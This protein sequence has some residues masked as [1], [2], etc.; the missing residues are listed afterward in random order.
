M[1]NKL[2]PRKI[3]LI[4]P[5]YGTFAGGGERAF[6]DLSSKFK[7]VGIEIEVL[8]TCSR[9]PYEDWRR[10]CFEPGTYQVDQMTVRR[11][12][13]DQTDPAP[14]Y[15]VVQ[16]RWRSEQISESMQWDFFTYGINSQV[17]IQ[18]VK[19]LPSGIPIIAGTYFQSLIPNLVNACPNRITIL[20]AFHDEPEFY[21]KPVQ[22]MVINAKQILFLSEEEKTLAIKAYGKIA[23]RKLVESPVVG[24]GV[25]LPKL[26][27]QLLLDIDQLKLL[28]AKYNLPKNYFIYVGRIEPA[29]GL[30]YLIPWVKEWNGS[31]KK[32]G[33]NEIPLV[34]VGDG[35][36]EIIPNSPDFIYAGYVSPEEKYGLIHESLALINPSTLESFSYV[37]MEAWLCGKPVLVPQACCVTAG[38]CERSE[39][40]MIFDD[41]E[42][43]FSCL[44]LLTKRNLNYGI[45][46]ENYVKNQY[47]WPEVM[48]R[49]LRALGD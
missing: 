21:W 23:G 41:Q 6:R 8:T 18:Y 44:N 27:T 26:A 39:G 16:A 33:L 47:G 29:K 35:A 15:Q 45:N 38:H 7:Q 4:T 5:W 22:E 36:K 37:I 11:F 1:I 10:D 20:P 24:L 49:V 34:L 46:G 25:Q 48:D 19:K 31:R 17:L 30:S 40:G 3:Y 9:S 12:A 2:P 28:R 32:L 42:S 14:Y 43:F 13:V